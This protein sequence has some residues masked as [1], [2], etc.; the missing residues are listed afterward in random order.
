MAHSINTDPSYLRN[1]QYR[2]SR[3]LDA[4]IALHDRFSINPYP[5]HRWLFDQL[6]L[7]PASRVLDVGC[8]AG[9]MWVKNRDRLDPTWEL[10][11]SDFSSG[12][13]NAARQG[14]AGGN[15]TVRFEQ[16]D[17]Q[18][19]PHA[20]DS[21]DVVIA[22]HMLYHVPDRDPAIAEIHRVLRA[23][24]RLYAATNGHAHLRELDQLAAPFAPAT[25]MIDSA[26]RFGL[27]TGLAQLQR[28]FGDVRAL[29]YE[30]GLVVT[31]AEPLIAYIRSMSAT[32]TISKE[33]LGKLRAHIDH[34]IAMRGAVRITKDSGLF[35]AMKS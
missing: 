17:A 7:P 21:F 32:A 2:D 5:W 19:I 8:G 26:T 34:E 27:E 3:N 9:T 24:G 1:V 13:L 31:D 20:D 15:L 28:R 29:R 30:D 18:S 35:V 6:A 10:T 22:N 25:E 4:R 23:G 11:L 14:L 16:V 33:A 12:M